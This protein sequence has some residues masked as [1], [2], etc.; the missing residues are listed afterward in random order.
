MTEQV[1][2]CV[3]CHRDEPGI[4]RTV[5]SLA[6]SAARLEQ[7]WRIVVC[8]NGADPGN[9]AAANALRSQPGM[10]SVRLLDV[11]SKPAAWTALREEPADIHV[12]ADADISVGKW[13]IPALVDGLR[14]AGVVGTAA[15]QE[16]LGDGTVAR[17]A[18]IPHRLY[19]GGLLGTLYAAKTAALPEVMPNG[20][21]LDDAWLF[22]HLGAQGRVAAA[23]LAVATV[24]LP[25][26]WRDLWRQRVRA[27]AGKQ[28][29]QAL[30]LPLAQPPKEAT[31]IYRTLVAYP[32]ADW[33]YV[34]A[35]AAIKFA[36]ARRARKGNVD[37]K[38]ATS[39][40]R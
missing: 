11:A 19:W 40:K 13:A 28:Q 23:P 29:M 39:T 20:V 26:R 21:L 15:K 14:E 38:L 25:S 33:P 17:V 34:A 1:V 31:S 27:E 30:D 36:A 4:A 12:F 6:E 10:A 3:P 35:L 18:R 24:Q 9:G 22:A 16:H 37:W 2:I 7:P 8:I 32:P 5:A